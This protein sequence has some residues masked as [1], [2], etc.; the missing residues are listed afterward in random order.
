MNVEVI[1]SLFYMPL[2]ISEVNVEGLMVIDA[3]K[4]TIPF[5]RITPDIVK[6]L[7]PGDIV[8]LEGSVFNEKNHWQVTGTE[9]GG[10]VIVNGDKAKVV[11]LSAIRNYFLIEV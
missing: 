1:A 5:K 4:E 6:M 8:A 2:T 10:L 11:G 7:I 3:V 9:E